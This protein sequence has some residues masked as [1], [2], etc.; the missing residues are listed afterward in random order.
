MGIYQTVCHKV[1]D[2]FVKVLTK[3]Q[4][5]AIIT[6]RV[7]QYRSQKEKAHQEKKE[8]KKKKQD[9]QKLIQ[10]QKR[11]EQEKQRR[12]LKEI[13]RKETEAL[14]SK[15]MEN[16]GWGYSQYEYNE[17]KNNK[18]FFQSLALRVFEVNETAQAF[19]FC[20]YDKSSKKEIKGYLIATNKRVLFLTKDLNH[21][22]KFRYQTI[23]N[24]NWFKDGIIER[25][26]RIQYGKRKL[27]FDEIFDQDQLQKVSKTIL[28]NSTTK[29]V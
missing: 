21:M 26:L 19:I 15:V 6:E 27:E 23:I 7:S 10:L 24:V 28:N 13:E 22:D 16:G 2:I 9:E 14:I 8:N 11:E 3:K 25:G 12:E 20:E 18:Q 17:I 29:A 4:D 5:S 1:E